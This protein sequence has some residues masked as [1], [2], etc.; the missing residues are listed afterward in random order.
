MSLH[1]D[2]DN[3]LESLRTITERI[4]KLENPV[5]LLNMENEFEIQRDPY[6]NTE[7]IWITVLGIYDDDLSRI[8]INDFCKKKSFI[9]PTKHHV[10][11]QGNVYTAYIR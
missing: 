8:L 11:S 4:S 6:K 2:I 5:S 10:S 3:K 9:N 7:L 1:F